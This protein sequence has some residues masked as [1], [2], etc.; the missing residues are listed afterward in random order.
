VSAQMGGSTHT[1]NVSLAF[2]PFQ[3]Q[4]IHSYTVTICIACFHEQSRHDPLKFVKGGVARVT[5]HLK[6]SWQS[7]GAFYL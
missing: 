1:C 6:F 5:C 7:L 3:D 4:Y 2:W